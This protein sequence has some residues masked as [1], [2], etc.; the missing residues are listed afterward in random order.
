MQWLSQKVLN[1]VQLGDALQLPSV[2][3]Q[4]GACYE[5]PKMFQA[6]ADDEERDQHLVS[7]TVD[8]QNQLNSMCV[9]AVD[10]QHADIS[11]L[12]PKMRITQSKV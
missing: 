8:W 6:S 1:N 10:A 2:V 12:L 9:E 5:E 4:G 7:E 11:R 3:V